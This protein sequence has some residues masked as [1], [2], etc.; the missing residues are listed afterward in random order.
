[1]LIKRAGWMV[2]SIQNR[3]TQTR[4]W[5]GSFPH[6]MY[7]KPV[8]HLNTAPVTGADWPGSRLDSM[9]PNGSGNTN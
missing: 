2:C 5:A 4:S 9:K 8:S 3:R 7:S 6:L 1:M